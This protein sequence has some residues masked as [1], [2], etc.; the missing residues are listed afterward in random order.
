MNATLVGSVAPDEL[1]ASI[2]RAG[3][4]RISCHS[5]SWDV[6]VEG[7]VV[8]ETAEF[9]KRL[10]CQLGTLHDSLKRTLNDV[11][12]DSTNDTHART[13]VDLVLRLVD[14]ALQRT[15]PEPADATQCHTH[16]KVSF[17][18]RLAF[19]GRVVFDFLLDEVS[20][21]P[22]IAPLSD[23]FKAATMVPEWRVYARWFFVNLFQQFRVE[24]HMFQLLELSHIICQCWTTVLAPSQSRVAHAVTA[25]P[26]EASFK[27]LLSVEIA[28]AIVDNAGMT[29]LI[30]PLVRHLNNVEQISGTSSATTSEMVPRCPQS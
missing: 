27:A 25:M 29:P 13:S 20:H 6:S 7:C 17:S 11:A 8:R 22:S 21:F 15:A 16:D 4:K 26:T 10:S 24:N 30:Q 1:V 28:D 14:F 2:V 3:I 9:A 12:Q 18:D 19:V 23:F 5:I